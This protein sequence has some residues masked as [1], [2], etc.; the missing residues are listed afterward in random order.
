M[1][2]VYNKNNFVVFFK[3]K[4]DLCVDETFFDVVRWFDIMCI[5]NFLWKCVFCCISCSWNAF[6]TINSLNVSLACHFFSDFASFS[7]FKAKQ[8]KQAV[9][10]VLHVS[11]I[12]LFVSLPEQVWE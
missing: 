7:E 1:W 6:I 4:I 2:Y 11:E 12:V 5:Q 3:T 8:A 10:F 9:T